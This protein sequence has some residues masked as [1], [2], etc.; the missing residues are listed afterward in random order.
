MEGDLMAAMNEV[1]LDDSEHNNSHSGHSQFSIGDI[2]DAMQ[3]LLGDTDMGEISKNG[4]E[5][6]G[7]EEIDFETFLATSTATDAKKGDSRKGDEEKK[8]DSTTPA[9]DLDDI[10]TNTDELKSKSQESEKDSFELQQP[11][12]VPLQQF[13]NAMALIQDLENR[14]AV[15]ETGRQCLQDENEK[16]R[17]TTNQQATT[18]ANMEDKLSRFPKLLEETVQE[19]AK[20]AAAHAETEAKNSFWRKDL[21]RQE[22]EAKEEKLKKNRAGK[23]ATTNSLKQSD[24][25]AQVVERKEQESPGPRIRPVA[26]FN[27]IKG[28]AI[29]GWGNRNGN[30]NNNNKESQ[31]KDGSMEEIPEL[32]ELP[33]LG[34]HDSNS[35]SHHHSLNF[36]GDEPIETNNSIEDDT[37]DSKV[38]DLMTWCTSWCTMDMRASVE[39]G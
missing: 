15:L 31:K 27:A 26:M 10:A 37:D 2:D 21:A 32:P 29:R 28:Q 14:I 33:N 11:Q 25:L 34:S 36:D 24:F 18:I 35:S 4:E 20:L 23:M 30:N 3:L 13:L 7:I 17:E 1:L 5:E 8:D 19:E 22:Q 6:D 38:L 39:G 16:L 12:V 9:V